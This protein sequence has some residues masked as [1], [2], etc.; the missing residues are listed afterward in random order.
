MEAVVERRLVADWGHRP[1]P[2]P[3]PA[4]EKKDAVCT[5]VEGEISPG[6][7]EDQAS[8]SE[9]HISAWVLRRTGALRRAAAGSL[10][11]G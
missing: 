10:G 5:A 7:I 1:A 8:G 3:I 6:P 4:L 2:S 11:I 9:D